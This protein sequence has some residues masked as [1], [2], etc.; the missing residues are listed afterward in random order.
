[1][2]PMPRGAVRRRPRSR[3]AMRGFRTGPRVARGNRYSGD[4][5]IATG[6]L[7]GRDSICSP[8]EARDHPI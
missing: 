7:Q 2:K 1:M 4:K 8:W 6:R 5:V 3:M